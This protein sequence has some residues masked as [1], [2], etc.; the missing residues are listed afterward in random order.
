M[1]EVEKKKLTTLSRAREALQSEVRPIVIEYKERKKKKKKKTINDEEK[2]NYSKGLEDAQR[3]E[4]NILHI[5]KESANALSKGIDTYERERN[6]SAK[7]KKDGAI[8]DFL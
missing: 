8:E 5:T 7:E 3:L 6:I 1:N 4:G 2:E